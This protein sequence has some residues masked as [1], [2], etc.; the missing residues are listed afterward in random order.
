MEHQTR[1]ISVARLA[2]VLAVSL[3]LAACEAAAPSPAPAA[4]QA[5]AQSPT[6]PPATEATATQA[7]A[8]AATGTAAPAA[9]E[10]P[11]PAAAAAAKLNLNTATADDFLQ[12]PNVGQRMVREFMEYRPYDSIQQFRREIGKYVDAAQVAEYEKHVYVPVSPNNADAETLQQL[13]GVDQAAAEALIAARPFATR[14]DFLKKLAELVPAVDLA[15]A[16][17]YVEAE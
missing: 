10:A 8:P 5:P 3:A 9:T 2:A 6:Q 16:A 13:P 7:P 14:D 1:R 15:A 12:I 11:P 17:A 4:T